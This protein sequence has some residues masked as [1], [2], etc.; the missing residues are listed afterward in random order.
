MAVTEVSRQQ[1]QAG[2]HIGA[3]AVP[4]QQRRDGNECLRSLIRGRTGGAPIP[5]TPT[6][7][8]KVLLT[9]G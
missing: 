8:R 9:L 5:A 6:N 4:A 3:V 1:W 7:L 2:L